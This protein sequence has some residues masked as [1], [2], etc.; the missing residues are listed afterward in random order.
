MKDL[1][2][3]YE[4]LKIELDRHL[5]AKLMSRSE[6]F[7]L[8]M[9]NSLQW[10]EKISFLRSPWKNTNQAIRSFSKD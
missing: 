7:E 9:K 2:K 3:N 10:W 8:K 6:R 1:S 4:R 5:Q